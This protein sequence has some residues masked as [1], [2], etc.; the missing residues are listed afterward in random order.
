MA[1]FQLQSFQFYGLAISKL[2]FYEKLILQIILNYICAYYAHMGK[3]DL[4]FTL[5]FG[6]LCTVYS[7]TDTIEL[8]QTHSV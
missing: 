3:C 4:C 8:K 1:C 2:V 5:G 6:N 7:K